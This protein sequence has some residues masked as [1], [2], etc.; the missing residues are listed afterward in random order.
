M[1]FN[2]CWGI[3]SYLHHLQFF[4]KRMNKIKCTIMGLTLLL[5]VVFIT[6]CIPKEAKVEPMQQ[7]PVENGSVFQMTASSASWKLKP[8]ISLSAFAY[9]NQI[10][11]PLLKVKQGNTIYINFTNQI[12]MNTTIHWHG[13]RHKN[14]DDGVPG[15]TQAPVGP[16]QSYIYE[17]QFPDSGLYW[18]HPHVREDIQQEKGLYGT[19]LVEPT[20]QRTMI[21]EEVLILD[22]VL[23][24][25]D[26]FAPFSDKV[27]NFALMGRFGNT[28]FVNGKTEFT[29]SV[30]QYEP[31][32]LYIVNVANVR[33]FN[34]SIEGAEIA[35]VGTD[36]GFAEPYKANSVIIA[37]A[38]RYIL[39]VTFDKPG[40]Y[41]LM[42][43]NPSKSYVLGNILVKPS[44]NQYSPT[45][46]PIPK[47]TDYTAY[48][49]KKPDYEF[50]LTLEMPM[51]EMPHV[52]EQKGIEWE[53]TMFE[54]NRAHHNKLITWIIEDTTSKKK[55]MDVVPEVK[56]GSVKKIRFINDQNSDHPMQHPIHLHGQRFLVLSENGKIN[57]HLGWKDTVLVPAGSTIDI[58]VEFTNPGDW[59]MHCHIAEHLESGMMMM[60]KV[61]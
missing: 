40:T 36:L 6:A 10:P 12:P 14:K 20:N 44:T 37:P 48:L 17:L 23:I 29:L 24:E 3:S 59:M 43:K 60:F 54:M 30:N 7:Y 21:R 56:L 52:E 61:R 55:N 9:N 11:G 8:G 34:L 45:E 16:G 53:D 46:T 19:I 39:D 41:N 2:H 22:D 32:R 35:I 5:L 15:V 25:G 4:Q 26:D 49:N 1:D 47:I 13:L 57:Q 28:L 38:E 42:N 18:Y 31:L 33:P 50:R 51:M 27:T 58:L